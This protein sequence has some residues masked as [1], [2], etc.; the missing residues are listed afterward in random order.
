[1]N[2]SYKEKFYRNLE[3]RVSFLEHKFNQ[4]GVNVKIVRKRTK[5]SKEEILSKRIKDSDCFES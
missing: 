4:A 2:T 1:M 5:K 3:N